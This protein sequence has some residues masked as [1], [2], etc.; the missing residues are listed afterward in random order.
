MGNT[1]NIT[2]TDR[3]PV[4]YTEDDLEDDGLTNLQTFKRHR[5][6]REGGLPYRKANSRRTVDRAHRRIQKSHLNLE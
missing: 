6:L 2:F 5:P 3:L 4:D 1:N